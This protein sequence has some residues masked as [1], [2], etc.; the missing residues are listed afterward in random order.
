MI[1][2][3]ED[4]VVNKIAAGEVIERPASVV[5]ELVE[6][7]IDAGATD[8]RVELKDGGRNLIRVTDNGCGMDR[9]DATL[10]LER[11][12][13]SKIRSDQDLFQISTLGFRGEAIPSIA[14]VSRFELL[15]RP[16][17]REVGTR[18]SVEGGRLVDISDAGCPK[19][20]RITARSLFFNIP[21]RRKF[22]RTV[23]TEL[24]H[25]LEAVVRESLIRPALDVEVT[26][27]GQKVIRAPVVSDLAARAADM[28]GGHGAALVPVSFSQG[29]MKVNGLVSPVGVHK[30]SASGS[31]YMY[32]NGR[33][34][35]DPVLRR[36]LNEAYRGIVPKGRYPTVVLQIEIPP[37]DVDVNVHPAKT[38]VRFRHARDLSRVLA[39]GVRRALQ[40]HGIQQPVPTEARYQPAGMKAPTV[41]QQVLA[42]SAQTPTHSPSPALQQPSAAQGAAQGMSLGALPR[43]PAVP[44]P[45]L[46]PKPLIVSPN[47]P[48]VQ[49]PSTAVNPMDAP[50]QGS[51]RGLLPVERFTDLR[52]IGQLGLTYV[53]CE[54]AGELVIVDQHAAHERI[55]LY[56][57]LQSERESMGTGQR[58]LSPLIVE[59]TPSRALALLPH[60]NVLSRYGLEVEPFGGE[61]FAVK[62]VP[63]ALSKANLQQLIE[64]VADDLA[65][66]GT[67]E[68][69]RDLVEKVLATM[70]CHNSIRA[71][72]RLNTFE[73]RELL[74]QLDQVDFSVCA[75][76]RPVTIRITPA[77]LE[78]RF[79]RS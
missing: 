26:H 43:M 27:N 50:A 37:G 78:R 77:E 67:G 28:L 45:Q 40:Q 48:V 13:T 24:S 1:R 39:G 22:L 69:A 31:S 53:L 73:M 47:A 35:R 12:A 65:G 34:V 54:G 23:A 19:G 44:V 20:T 52:V 11:H 72:Q 70:A 76:G 59:L 79:H 18:V 49:Q 9:S 61:A 7:A 10:C 21:A 68:P 16:A 8:I 74:S 6:N 32:V 75:H 60:T 33:F 42:L 46:V 15:S 62:Q 17:D 29:A 4:R 57:L 25:C 36:A 55:T 66:G 5:K 41:D 3:L 38:E 2:I 71:G 58:L 30:A 63:A 64:D 14:S 56:K 51:S